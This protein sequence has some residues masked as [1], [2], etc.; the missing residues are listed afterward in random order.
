MPLIRLFWEICLLR[1]GPQDVPASQFLLMLT[2]LAYLI[3]GL[4]QVFLG[5]EWLQGLLQI[6]LQAA[7]LLGFSWISLKAANKL[8]RQDQTFTALLGT[9]A[10]LS[11]FAIPMQLM[12]WVDPQG[13]LTHLLLL[14][15][16]LWHM[17]VV[18]HIFREAL[19]QTWMVG[20]GLSFVLTIITFQTLLI[21]FGMPETSG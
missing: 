9:D 14:M 13:G 12:L 5:D 16:M 8:N 15:L 19:S 6:P 1:K 7:I 10:V 4:V 2:G 21:L 18:G 17:L 3:V 11:C 20:M